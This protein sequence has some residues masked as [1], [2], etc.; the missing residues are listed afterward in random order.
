MLRFI[1][2]NILTGLVTILPVVLTL[3]LLYWFAVSAESALGGLIRLVL[4]ENLYWP[5]MGLIAGLV[6]VFVVALITMLLMVPAPPFVAAQGKNMLCLL[7]MGMSD[8]PGIVDLFEQEP[9]IPETGK[10]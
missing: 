3:Y 6:V 2:R 8:E 10:E 4:P 1:S 7:K 5:G 9:S